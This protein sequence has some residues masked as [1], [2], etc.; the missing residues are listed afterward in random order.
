MI[1]RTDIKYAYTGQKVVIFDLTRSQEDHFNYEVMESLKNGIFFSSKYESKM[2]IY[3]SPHVIV[4]S[5][6]APQLNKMSPDRWDLQTDMDQSPTTTTYKDITTPQDEATPHQDKQPD[7]LT[8][9]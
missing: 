5:N 9:S 8:H 2:K 7:N 3:P 4:F 1:K 6:W